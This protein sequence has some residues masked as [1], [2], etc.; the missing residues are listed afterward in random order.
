MSGDI[1]NG[2]AVFA[3][4]AVVLSVVFAIYAGVRTKDATSKG[5]N[6]W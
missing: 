6:R 4:C 2:T 1:L 5:A 3:I